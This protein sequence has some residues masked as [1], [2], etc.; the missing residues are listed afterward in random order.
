MRPGSSD[1]FPAWPDE[2]PA[3]EAVPPSAGPDEARALRSCIRDLVSLSALSAMW[4]EAVP[5]AILVGLADA[6][7]A[8]LRLDVVCARLDG[9][10]NAAAIEVVRAPGGDAG[11][12]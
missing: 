3:G 10:G 11:T 2:A 12:R 5:T 6:L 8:T 7:I 1:A 4:G 9:D